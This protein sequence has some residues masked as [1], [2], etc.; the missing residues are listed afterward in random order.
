MV[1][2]IKSE[3]WASA[4]SRARFQALALALDGQPQAGVPLSVQA[5]ARST[6]TSRKRLVGGSTAMTTRPTP[7]L[8]TV[9]TGKSDARGLLLCDVALDEPG[10]IE[11]VVSARDADGNQAEAATSVWVTRR[12]ELWFGGQDHDRIDLL[13]EKKNYAPGETARLQV[14]MPFRFATALVTVER[15]G[16]IDSRVVQLNGHGPTISLKI[17]PGWAP[18]VYVSALVLRGR[19]REVP[20]YSFFTWGFKAPREWWNAF[21]YEGREYVAPTAMAPGQA[22]LSPGCG[23]AAGGR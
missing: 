3:G 12:G 8:G 14:R 22:G 17:E 19:L 9:C 21:W 6:T 15:E 16:V 5:I 18:N 10:E 4:N 2:G 11:L 23:A 13:P 20:W 1:A 7:H